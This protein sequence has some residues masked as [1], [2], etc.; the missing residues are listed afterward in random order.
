MD[1]MAEI[2]AA[3]FRPGGFCFAKKP[4]WHSGLGSEV[5]ESL[6]INAQLAP[7]FAQI[8]TAHNYAFNPNLKQY[9]CDRLVGRCESTGEPSPN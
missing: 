5:T 8:V 1:T 6:S 4:R 2:E 3:G 7:R 9:G